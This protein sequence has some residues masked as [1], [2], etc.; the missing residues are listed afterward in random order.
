MKREK[1]ADR[2]RRESYLKQLE[3]QGI[4]TSKLQEGLKEKSKNKVVRK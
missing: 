3:D 1:I 2:M 4:N